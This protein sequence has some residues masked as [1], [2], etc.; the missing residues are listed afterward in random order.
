MQLVNPLRPAII[1]GSKV[2]SKITGN[3]GDK[4][5]KLL[6]IGGGMIPFTFY[7][8]RKIKKKVGKSLRKRI[9]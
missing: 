6:L 2:S 8:A 7:K 4:R 1:G 9:N 5:D 3:T